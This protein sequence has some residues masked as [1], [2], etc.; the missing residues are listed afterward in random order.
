GRAAGFP[1]CGTSENSFLAC[2]AGCLALLSRG[3]IFEIALDGVEYAV[4]KLCRLVSRETPCNLERFVDG[5]RLGGLWL[6]KK[7]VD[8]EPDEVAVDDCHARDAPMLSAHLDP[9]INGIEMSDGTDC[10][11]GSELSD[12][13]G[14]LG[15]LAPVGPH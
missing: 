1:A 2:G 8:C 7:F 13:L 15:D 4:D 11:I 5:Y 14:G 3:G 6:E 10:E 9:L 12:V